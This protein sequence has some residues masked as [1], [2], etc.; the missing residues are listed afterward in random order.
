MSGSRF[1][2]PVSVASGDQL[3]GS[4][5]PRADQRNA[6]LPELRP[7]SLV[8]DSCRVV[9]RRDGTS[10]STGRLSLLPRLV[11]SHAVIPDGL[12]CS[13]WSLSAMWTMNALVVGG[14]V[15]AG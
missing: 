6:G 9:A 3:F 1:V 10:A 11:G 2:S 5:L 7:L 14:V 12:T 13:A 15:T 4:T 8:A